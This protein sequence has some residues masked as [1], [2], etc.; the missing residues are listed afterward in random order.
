MR[1]MVFYIVKSHYQFSKQR[2]C[3]RLRLARNV[4]SSSEHVIIPSTDIEEENRE[5]NV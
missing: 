1:K 4:V 5:S 2:I 3:L